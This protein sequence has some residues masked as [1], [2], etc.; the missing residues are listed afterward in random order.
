MLWTLSILFFCIWLL[1]ILTPS[2]FNGYI[3]IL[4]LL[5]AG[6]LLFRFFGQRN[7]MD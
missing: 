6:T 7:A 1:G 5:A 2:T 4:L 3:H